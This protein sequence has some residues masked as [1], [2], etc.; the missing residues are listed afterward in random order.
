MW[1]YHA[2]SAGLGWTTTVS[3]SHANFPYILEDRVGIVESSETGLT[4]SSRRRMRRREHHW[5]E[6]FRIR[7]LA[8]TP[9]GEVSPR[10]ALGGFMSSRAITRLAPTGVTINVLTSRLRELNLAISWARRAAYTPPISTDTND[11]S[12]ILNAALTAVRRL[13]TKEAQLRALN[14]AIQSVLAARAVANA[15]DDVS[16]AEIIALE[17]TWDPTP[18]TVITDFDDWSVDENRP[19]TS[20]T[21][22]DP[23]N[24]L[25]TAIHASNLLVSFSR[26][27]PFPVP[28]AITAVQRGQLTAALTSILTITRE[29]RVHDSGVGER[30]S[31]LPVGDD[32]ALVLDSACI[33][34]YACVADT[35]LVPCWHLMLCAVCVSSSHIERN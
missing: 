9:M 6:E 23:S 3:P 31:A 26:A 7:T 27:W 11:D 29:V 2:A 14:R 17:R 24:I 15:I 28:A 12:W 1:P 18:P 22:P 16:T 21:A 19:Y 34:C 33:V 13:E 35:V 5:T 20:L 10:A 32:L 30:L 4:K 25:G 8:R